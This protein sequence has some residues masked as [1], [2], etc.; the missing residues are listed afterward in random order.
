MKK[1][2]VLALVCAVLT[3]AAAAGSPADTGGTPL[4]EL[5]LSLIRGTGDP[6]EP[7]AVDY[8]GFFSGVRTGLA[9]AAGISALFPGG[10]GFAGGFAL[11]GLTVSVGVSLFC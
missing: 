2:M 5:D 3:C 10:Q 6:T 11:A 7:P 4:S 8:C 9:L 1:M